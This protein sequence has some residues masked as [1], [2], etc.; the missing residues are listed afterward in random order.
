MNE[1]EVKN[2]EDWFC[3]KCARLTQVLFI[4]RPDMIYCE[5]CRGDF[6]KKGGKEEFTNLRKAKAAIRHRDIY[7]DFDPVL[8]GKYLK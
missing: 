6:I 3:G 1:E 4:I 7:N 5:S 2:T 8:T